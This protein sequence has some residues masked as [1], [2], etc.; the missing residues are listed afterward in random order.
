M[1]IFF[2]QLNILVDTGSSN[3][4]VAGAPNAELTTYFDSE[5][6]STYMPLGIEVSVKYTQGSWIGTLGTDIIT[7]P[8]GI[9]GTY[10]INIATISQSDNFFLKGIKWQGILG[11]AYDALAKILGGI[12]PSLYKGEIWY[13]PIQREWYYQVEILKLEVGGQNLN[14]DCKEYNSDKAIVDSGT[15]LLRLPEKVFSAVVEAIIQSSLIQE[16]PSGFWSGTQLACW[17]KTEK[18]W[19]FFPEISIYLRDENV[20]RSFRITILPQLY[21]QPVL[22]Y[23]Q[24]LACYRFGISSSNN[25]L[26]IGATVMEGFYVIFDRAQKRVGFALS[27]CAAILLSKPGKKLKKLE[28]DGSPVSEIK[29]PFT[30]ADVASTCVSTISLHEPLLW[31]V[32][33]TLMSFCGLVLL[34]LV[35]LLLL[36]PRCRHHYTDNDIVNDES[37]LVRHRWK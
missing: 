9:N 24:N 5:K 11:L 4:A 12:E 37:S 17:V 15:T 14:L 21:I 26:V 34:V 36:P 20:S 1:S 2:L 25:A 23:G 31:I 7:M 8:K 10:T 35:I 28:I 30:T 16:F 27:T 29:G 33:Y 32:S 3:F 18:P 22:E 19:T 13:T 6:S